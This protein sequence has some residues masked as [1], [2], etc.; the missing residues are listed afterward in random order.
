VSHSERRSKTIRR[1]KTNAINILQSLFTAFEQAYFGAAV[2]Y[3]RKL[4]TTLTT[5]WKNLLG[6]NNL[7]DTSDGEKS[8]L[9]LVPE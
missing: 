7:A 4:L 3:S 9:T 5:S 8:F 1:L 6:T 2:S